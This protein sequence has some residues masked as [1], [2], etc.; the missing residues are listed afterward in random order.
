MTNDGAIRIAMWSG[1]R[2]ISTAM[3]R[4]F[5]NRADT[6]VI[7]EPFYACFLKETGLDH[8][9]SD[10]ILK[11]QSSDWRQ[12]VKDLMAP[13]PEGRQIF[14]QKHMTHHILP[15]VGREWMADVRNAF[16]IRD[17]Y[18]M[19]R[20]YVKSRAEVTLSD[21]GILQQKDIFDHVADHLGAAPP[22]I[23]SAD[24]LASPKEA[25]TRLCNALDIPFDASML[26][27]PKGKRDSDGIWA[28]W[29]YAGVEQST[30]FK[31]PDE[32]MR[33]EDQAPLVPEHQRILD[34]A[35]PVYEALSRFK[36]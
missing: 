3:M 2:N 19:L 10:L 8:P 5:E 13:L 7:D 18:R 17:P 4:S 11:E 36:V 28:P 23:D 22:V 27:W 24:I 20:S 35:M 30:G 32:E 6:V 9:G 21:L 14:Y 34:A 12:V 25:L 1:P 31:T 26:T 33:A 16:L 15:S 29:W